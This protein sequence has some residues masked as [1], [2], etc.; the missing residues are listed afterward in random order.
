MRLKMLAIL[1]AAIGVLGACGDDKPSATATSDTTSATKG[2]SG[3]GVD[4]VTKALGAFG[5][6]ECKKASGAIAAAAGAIPQ[7]LTGGKADV[8][9]SITE[10][11]AFA[12]GAPSD[13]RPSIEVLAR[14]YSEIATALKDADYD[15][16]SGK[17]PSEET[18]KKLQAASERLDGTEFQEAGERVNA[19]FT[20]ECGK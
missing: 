4:D 17:A 5:S 6:A 16:A 12:K 1:M 13:I 9:D 19:W 3:T 20:E 14:G 18:L 10:L 11:E 15:P 7:A 2:S 8:G